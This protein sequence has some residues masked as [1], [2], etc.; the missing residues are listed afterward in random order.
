MTTV[1]RAGAL[2]VTPR[3]PD[4]ARA[5]ASLAERLG[6]LRDRPIV[7]LGLSGSGIPVAS[8]VARALG[9]P[10]D[11][12]AVER[13]PRPFQ[14][15]VALA[16]VAEDGVL[17]VDDAV[18]N[19]MHIGPDHVAALA[20]AARASVARTVAGL[21]G[22][23]PARRLDGATAVVVGDGFVTGLAARAAGRVARRRGAARVVLAAPVVA[24]PA[25]AA[26]RREA[27]EVVWL[28][29]PPGTPSVPDFYGDIATGDEHP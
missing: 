1:D 19:G 14:P 2:R 21:R 15:G 25:A 20:A 3:F 12:V 22:A 24:A 17:A 23:E 28:V 26:C 18:V 8:A 16:A 4:R 13:V 7:V 11:V 6:H 27:D 5:G 9:A 29:S 10:A